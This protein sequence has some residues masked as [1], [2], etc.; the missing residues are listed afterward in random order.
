MVYVLKGGR[1]SERGTYRELVG[2]EGAF[3][4]FLI[5]HLQESANADKIHE[6]DL[7]VVEGILE[8]GIVRSHLIR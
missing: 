1:I 6:E 2:H 7:S 5:Q 8:E 4:D 3:A